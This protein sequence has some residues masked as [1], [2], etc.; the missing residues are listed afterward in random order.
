[1]RLWAVS[2]VSAAALSYEVLLTRL[3]AIVHWHNF[4]FMVISLALLGYG[5]SGTFIAILRPWLAARPAAAFAANAMAFAL[6]VVI[7]FEVAQRLPFNALA[8]FW[9]PAQVLWLAALYLLFAVPFFFAANA[10][11][12]ALAF[13]EEPVARIYRQDL[14]GAGAGALAVIGLLFL[15]PAKSG[16]V[17]VAGV[18]LLA[19]LLVGAD[20]ENVQR[21]PSRR[22]RGL[23]A[24]LAL[25]MVPFLIAQL[26]ISEFKGLSQTL[27]LPG[28]EVMDQRSG[29]LG[30]VTVL[31]SERV[32]FRHAPGLSLAAEVE[33]AEQRAYF[34]DG[35]GMGA[36]TRFDGDLAPLAY[37]DQV[38]GALPYHLVDRPEVLVLG[39]GGGE[40]VLRGLYHRAR[41]I[42]AVEL[43]GDLIS[44]ARERHG[45]FAGHLYE[46]PEVTVHIADARGFI[47]ATRQ[48]FDLIQLPLSGTSAGAGALG[49]SY[50]YTVEAF[51][52]Y[53]DRLAPGG[54]LAVTRHVK[55]PPRDSLK[56]VATAREALGRTGVE[57]ARA[58][59]VL[60][61]SW[62]TTT[63][64][65]KNGTIA[66][67]DI[68]A[69]RDFV[70]AR[71]FDLVYHPGMVRGEAN[72]FNLLAEP[73]FHDGTVALLGPEAGAFQDRYK[74]DLR[75]ARDDRPYFFDFF[76]W[77]A[78]PEVLAASR[79]GGAVLLDW[80]HLILVATLLQAAVFALL[81]ILAPLVLIE[82]RLPRTRAKV[83]A[84]AYF[85]LIGLAFLFIEIASIQR[86]VLFLGHPLYALAVVLAAFLVFAGLG[87]GASARLAARRPAD[88]LGLAVLAIAVL[89][90][91][92]VW[93]LP[94]AF[95]ALGG[96]AVA[97]KIALAVILIAPL[98]FAM[99]MPFPIV[100]ARLRETMPDFVPWA[101]GVNGA[102]SVLAAVLAALLAMAFGFGAVALLALVCYLG[103]AVLG[104]SIGAAAQE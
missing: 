9:Q 100:L 24:L 19:A 38:T 26:R 1:M 2:L 17:A 53:L 69:I 77:R 83:R 37:L 32:P 70:T 90:L 64:A 82:R 8:L 49:E 55:L 18:A 34:I 31:G 29:P 84:A 65:I 99:G 94:T 6:A 60:I 68:A 30:L 101:W 87:S 25:A 13:F 80:G 93:L 86:F 98:A 97:A 57:D 92:H 27:R 45:A 40:D 11:G 59:L 71:G 47:A 102:A 35:G 66:A 4:A 10:I 15:L 61:R 62:A 85:L 39:A 16:L 76:R 74:F 36:I 63:L 103:A 81:L 96:L 56:L 52:R 5:A 72:R 78:L 42:E 28:V 75:P 12:L 79:L 44:L 54:W 21:S 23:A 48:R 20:A 43:N 67:P 50:L 73:A 33:P 22:R 14:L 91:G 58:R 41:R 51:E 46:R 104:R 7:G 3:L 89:T 95:E 88:A